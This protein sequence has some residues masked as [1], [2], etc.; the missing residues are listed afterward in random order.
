MY[1]W[2]VLTRS[3]Q[4]IT[5]P[6]SDVHILNNANNKWDATEVTATACT[7][8]FEGA[9]LNHQIKVERVGEEEA[10]AVYGTKLNGRDYK[11]KVLDKD[12]KP[13]ANGLVNVGLDEVMDRNLTTN[14]NAKFTNVKEASLLLLLRY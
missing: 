10:A 12:G 4:I 5:G 11:V 9:Q 6:G 13:Y 2:T 3:E 7:S 1:S 14:S 8:K